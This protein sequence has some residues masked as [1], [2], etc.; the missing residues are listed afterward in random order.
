MLKFSINIGIDDRTFGRVT[1]PVNLLRIEYETH[2]K[3]H[4]SM[5]VSVMRPNDGF[6][7]RVAEAQYPHPLVIEVNERL[8]NTISDR[9]PFRNNAFDPYPPFKR[10]VE[11]PNSADLERSRLD[12]L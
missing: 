10:I 6:F 7:E 3:R 9:F 2:F 8:Y 1:H 4:A 12:R 5:L 11:P